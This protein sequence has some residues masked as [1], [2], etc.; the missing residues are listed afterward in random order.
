M[1]H[2]FNGRVD[3]KQKIGE[4]LIMSLKLYAP[5]RA[6]LFPWSPVDTLNN[7]LGSFFE[8]LPLNRNAGWIP[9][10]SV[11]E[12]G[13]VILLTAETPGLGADDFTVELEDNVLTI[14]GEKSEAREEGDEDRRIHL[15]ERR[16]GSFRRSF[17]LPR[18]V[19]A[20]KIDA[21]LENGILTVSLPKAAESKPRLIKVSS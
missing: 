19:D 1:T 7:R 6:Q 5:Q 14:A 2:R 13:D 4:S 16:Y 8:D 12:A 9:P 15:S 18:T 17:T 20:K 21:R 11:E 10:V 3:L